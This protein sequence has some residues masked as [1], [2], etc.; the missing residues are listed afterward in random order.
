MDELFT[1]VAG[2]PNGPAL[3]TAALA[4]L[5]FNRAATAGSAI[6]GRVGPAFGNAR[7]SI[8]Q[9]RKDLGTVAS[10]WV[11]ASSATEAESKK[12]SAATDRLKSNMATIGKGANIGAGLLDPLALTLPVSAAVVLIRSGNP[13]YRQVPA[14]GRIGLLTY[15]VQL[16]PYFGRFFPDLLGPA[17]LG[18][19]PIGPPRWSGDPWRT[20][21]W[22]TGEAEDSGAEGSAPGRSLRRLLVPGR[23]RAPAWINLWRRTDPLGFPVVGYESN[24]IDRGAEEVDRSAYL[25]EVGLHGGYPRTAAYQEALDEVVSR[26]DRT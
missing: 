23:A 16:R 10:G 6:M 14:A 2:S 9:M 26:L 22:E 25:F 20:D 13:V 3:T 18:L 7:A 15:G 1:A 19:P 5:A 17:M 8:G 4:M 21:G 12:M 24:E 11:L